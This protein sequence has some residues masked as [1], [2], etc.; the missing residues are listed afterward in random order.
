MIEPSFNG[1]TRRITLANGTTS[2]DLR[3]LHSWW[4]LWVLAGNAE[5]LIAFGTIGGEIPAIPLYLFLQNGWK[6]VP[7]AADHVLNITGGVLETSDGSDPFVDPAGA[8]KIRIYRQSPGIAIGYTTG[9]GVTAQD[10]TDIAAATISASRSSP[11]YSLEQSPST[12]AA[13]V[14]SE[15]SAE[16]SRIDKA[17]STRATPA[18]IVSLK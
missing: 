17:V 12:T 3:E 2:V 9:S 15:L 16:L 13:A 11:I 14:R 1:T 7:Q 10:K 6:I 4:K 18:D 5:Y 8:Y